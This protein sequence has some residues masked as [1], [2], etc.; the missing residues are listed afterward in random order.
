M[1]PNSTTAL[2]CSTLEN[3]SLFVRYICRFPRNSNVMTVLYI[4]IPYN[5][6]L[7][8]DQR[9]ANYDGI[10]QRLTFCLPLVTVSSLLDHVTWSE[11]YIFHTFLL[12]T[13]WTSRSGL[14]TIKSVFLNIRL[15]FL[16][17]YEDHSVMSNETI[18]VLTVQ[19]L[20]PRVPCS[21][22]SLHVS[23]YSL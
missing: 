10:L 17:P 13:V 18:W 20:S 23:N 11:I 2:P 15:V 14:E 7:G 22:C 19:Y 6:F 3:P 1:V 21:L 16:V 5:G 12:I 4:F 8:E 9:V